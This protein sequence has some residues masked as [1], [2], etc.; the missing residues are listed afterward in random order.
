MDPSDLVH[1]AR[2]LVRTGRGKPKQVELR[3]AISACY[4][5]VFHALL[6]AAAD[7]LIGGTRKARRSTAYSLVYRGFEHNEMRRVCTEAVKPVLPRKMSE[8]LK[9]QSFPGDIKVVARIFVELQRQRHLADYD[10]NFRF[11]K[12]DALTAIEQAIIANVT[13]ETASDADRR[14]LLLS[15]LLPLR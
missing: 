9:I 14:N 12:S 6:R 5:N 3:R 8:A 7:D 4:Y 2:T 1:H 11:A 15:M 13:F 10:P